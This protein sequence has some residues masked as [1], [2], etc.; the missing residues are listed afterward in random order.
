MAVAAL[1]VVA[2]LAAAAVA[3]KLLPLWE[4]NKMRQTNVL[5]H[6]HSATVLFAKPL[7]RLRSRV[8]SV[9][10]SAQLA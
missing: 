10:T 5:A 7:R 6:Q 2:A 3:G 4:P 9:Q 8:A 1:V